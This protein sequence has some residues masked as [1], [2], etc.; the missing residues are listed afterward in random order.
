VF[1]VGEFVGVPMSQTDKSWFHVV[2]PILAC[3]GLAMAS[4]AATN[5]YATISDRN[6]FGLKPPPPP[7]AVTPEDLEP[8][9]PPADVKI[10]GITTIMGI[11]RALVKIKTKADPKNKIPAEEKG[12]VMI[13]GEPPVDGVQVL[14]IQDASDPSD[15]KVRVRQKGKEFWL[16][17][18]KD[19]PKASAASA[20]GAVAANPAAGKAPPRVQRAALRGGGAPS[21]TQL[22]TTPPAIPTRRTRTGVATGPGGSGMPGIPG[23]VGGVR[24]A[25]AEPL[26][27]QGYQVNLSRTHVT[28]DYGITP[29]EQRF[30][31]E[32][33]RDVSFE[34]ELIGDVPPLPPTEDTPQDYYDA[35]GAPGQE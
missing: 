18:E 23:Y 22:G 5:P 11:P 25:G 3:S 6:V 9:E 32:A 19:T 30:L 26:Q 10:T 17:L 13:A 16:A 21:T 1:K 20:G 33:N 31:I 14:E 12:Y 2:V 29:E 34:Q 7:E 28:R 8:E 4:L 35:V 27:D 15:V 24:N